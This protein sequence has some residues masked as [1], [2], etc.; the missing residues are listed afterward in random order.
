MNAQ[1]PWHEGPAPFIGWWRASTTG[2]SRSW[3]WWNGHRWSRAAY[4]QMTAEQAARQAALPL[5][6]GTSLLVCWTWDWPEGAR[7][8][9]ARP[10]YRRQPVARTQNLWPAE[11]ARL[12]RTGMP[13]TT[14]WF[15]AATRPRDDLWR[16][17]DVL[18]GTWSVPVH[19]SATAEEAGELARLTSREP[20]PIRWTTR[21]PS[22]SR[23]HQRHRQPP[24]VFNHVR[25]RS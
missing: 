19:E 14:G 18:R 5:P 8:S 6:L 13:A 23:R 9:R 11:K 4:P 25:R 15:N 24:I 16:W 20:L 1:R 12:W 17:A 2:D 22:N 3:R 21:R 7:V 10:T